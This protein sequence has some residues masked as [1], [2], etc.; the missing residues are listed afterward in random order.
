LF[1]LQ[2]LSEENLALNEDLD[3]L[4]QI[5]DQHNVPRE[6]AERLISHT[7]LRHQRYKVTDVMSRVPHQLYL[8]CCEPLRNL[9]S[10]H[11]FFKDA[12]SGYINMVVP[13]MQETILL[14][15]DVL[16]QAGEPATAMFWVRHGTFIC[17]EFSGRSDD[18]VVT[19][20]HSTGGSFGMVGLLVDVLW[21][22]TVLAESTEDQA[23]VVVS[24]SRRAVEEPLEVYPEQAE[25]L[26]QARQRALR[27]MFANRAAVL[28][29]GLIR[30]L[31]IE[32]F[33]QDDNDCV[34]APSAGT[35]GE[36]S[37]S[38]PC[39]ASP[40]D[41]DRGTGRHTPAQPAEARIDIG[42]LHA[43]LLAVG[44]IVPWEE[45]ERIVAE[46]SAE[47]QKYLT[48]AEAKKLLLGP[49]DRPIESR[50]VASF[51][52]SASSPS[53]FGIGMLRP[54]VRTQQPGWHRSP[55]AMEPRINS[56]NGTTTVGASTVGASFKKQRSADGRQFGILSKGPSDSDSA[57]VAARQLEGSDHLEAEAGFRDDRS[58]PSSPLEVLQ[59]SPSRW[60]GGAALIPG[61]PWRRQW[62][63][64][65]KPTLR[66]I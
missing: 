64:C 21:M 12:N 11:E 4:M 61:R 40:P 51:Q 43:L 39:E 50:R 35:N 18:G 19:S 6:L 2:E 22:H 34:R 7:Y 5:V 47:S 49:N 1:W 41:S 20:I 9:L 63:R 52:C 15:G 54:D 3:E 36:S 55:T 59:R 42:Q 25:V 56:R 28:E 10:D 65:A 32:V 45:A 58:E 62:G 17:I 31:G 66:K 33:C 29:N 57:A 13:C 48:L 46:N 27:A 16:H 24:L 14:P 26:H 37:R 44:I 30:I 38:P 53:R 60:I 23:S 8:D